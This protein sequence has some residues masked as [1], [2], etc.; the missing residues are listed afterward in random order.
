VAAHA[1]I[2]RLVDLGAAAAH[3]KAEE[4]GARAHLGRVAGQFAVAR[5]VEQ[6]AAGLLDALVVAAQ[7]DAVRLTALGREA[8]LHPAALCLRDVLDEPAAAA[9]QAGVQLVRDA[10]LDR[11][12]ARL[13]T[14]AARRPSA[15]A[16]SAARTSSL[17]SCRSM[18]RAFSTFAFLPVMV[19]ASV[20]PPSVGRSMRVSVSSL[21]R[22]MLAPPFPMMC[23]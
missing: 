16:A 12:D 8:H 2:A 18:S 10:D 20:A 5:Q 7:R 6:H 11:H 15:H 23:G 9:D 22:L 21:I 17:S 14:T 3:Q 4:L 13:N 19:T 1:Q